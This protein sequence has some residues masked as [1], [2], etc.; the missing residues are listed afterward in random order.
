MEAVDEKA[1]QSKS[2]RLAI[3]TVPAKLDVSQCTMT[4]DLNYQFDD[5]ARQ[6]KSCRLAIERVP[7]KLDVRKCTMTYDLNYTRAKKGELTP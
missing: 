7:S 1:R 5:K 3:E 2:F 4:Y 6:S